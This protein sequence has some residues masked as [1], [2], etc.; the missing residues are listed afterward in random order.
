MINQKTD[1]FEGVTIT[2]RAR[3]GADVWDEFAVKSKLVQ[4]EVVNNE[5]RVDK[6]ADF[7]TRTISVEG[8]TFEWPKVNSSADVMQAAYASW[9][10][11]SPKLMIFWHNLIWDVNQPPLPEENLIPGND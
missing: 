1:T 2:V 8:L 4:I 9:C 11:F 10:E 3:I 5:Y 7:V 6:F